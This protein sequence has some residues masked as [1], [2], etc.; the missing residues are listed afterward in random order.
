[1]NLQTPVGLEEAAVVA[2]KYGSDWHPTQASEVVDTPRPQPPTPEHLGAQLARLQKQLSTM[3]LQS[4][5]QRG[6][7]TQARMVSFM[8]LATRCVMCHPDF[9][10]HGQ[11]SDALDTAEA[12]FSRP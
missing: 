7:S 8:D 6:A 9:Y 1:M 11:A 10:C 2:A 4:L 5:A 12:I 3:R